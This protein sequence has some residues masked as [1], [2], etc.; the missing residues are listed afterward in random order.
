ML[1]RKLVLYFY[2]YLGSMQRAAN[3][4]LVG[5]IEQREGLIQQL[6]YPRDTSV[7]E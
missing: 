6:D 1:S 7:S 2:K 5:N 3:L 4:D